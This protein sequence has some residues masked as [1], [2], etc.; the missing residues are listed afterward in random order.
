MFQNKRVIIGRYVILVFIIIIA[1]LPIFWQINNRGINEWDE[2]RNG[3]NAYEM[4]HN[5]DYFNLY[6]DGNV[7]TWNAKPP[8]YIW[9]VVLCNKIFGSNCFSLRLPS[10]IA[11]L[12]IFIILYIMILRAS[13]KS[14]ALLTCGIMLSCK[15]IISIHLGL[16][17]DFDS[18]FT[19][20]LICGTY[21]L[22]MYVKTRKSNAMLLSAIF[23]GVAWYTKGTAVFLY[24]VGI[25]LYILFYKRKFFFNKKN[26]YLS[27]VVFV[28]IVFSWFFIQYLYGKSGRDINYGTGNAIRTML[29]QDTWNRLISS[30]FQGGQPRD[31]LYIIEVLDSKMNIWNYVL[32][33]L[34]ILKLLKYKKHDYKILYDR[35]HENQLLVLGLFIIIPTSIIL[36]LSAN[37]YSWY[38]GP[39][40]WI[41]AYCIAIMISTLSRTWT[42]I[43]P[44]TLIIII[45]GYLRQLY[46]IN[47]FSKCNVKIGDNIVAN[48]DTIFAIGSLNQDVLLQLKWLNKPIKHI[49]SPNQVKNLS[50]A[51]IIWDSSLVG[52]QNEMIKPKGQIRSFLYN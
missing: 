21:Y 22:W 45:F 1:S 51:F 40:L 10:A 28:I 41:I 43:L 46:E 2:A 44:I 8:L 23:F 9:F 4:M 39:Y 37:K 3:V 52:L 30:K 14:I 19:L 26:V 29:V 47:T 18:T 36:S 24:L 33:I 50:R 6:Y 13:G 7:D 16:T 42:S 48:R 25:I 34:I 12:A 15:A 27:L 49:G 11:T 31:F 5:S 17:G 38:F 20:F 35:L 32:Y